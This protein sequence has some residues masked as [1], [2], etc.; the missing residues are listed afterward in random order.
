MIGRMASGSHP[1]VATPWRGRVESQLHRTGGMASRPVQVNGA[2]STFPKL[3]RAA[4][5]APPAARRHR[6]SRRRSTPR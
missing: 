4:T 5:E 3:N 2:P 6:F 1:D